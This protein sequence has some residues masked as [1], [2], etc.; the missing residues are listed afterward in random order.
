MD[1]FDELLESTCKTMIKTI[2]ACLSNAVKGTI[3]RI[4]LMPELTAVRITSGIRGHHSDVIEWGLPAKSDYN[5]PGKAWEEYRDQ[6][7]RVMEAMGWCVEKQ[8]SWTAD[9]PSEDLRSVR[10]QLAGEVEDHYHMEPVLVSKS[11]LYGSGAGRLRYPL[12]WRGNTI[13]RDSDYVVAAVIKIHFRPG[14]IRRDDGSTHIIR[15]LSQSLGTE[16]LSLYLRDTLFRARKDFARQRLQSCEILAHELRNTLAKL[17]FVFS[18]INAQIAILRESWEAHLREHVPGLE[19]K[20]TILERLSRELEQKCAGLKPDRDLLAAAEELLAAQNELARLSLSPYQE[21]EWVRNKIRPRW[22]RLLSRT[23]LWDRTEIIALLD[24]L[25]KSLRTGMERG[26]LGKINGI[27][28]EIVEKWSRLAYV[29]INSSNLFQI[30]EVIQ[31]V[32]YP[33]LPVAHKEQIIRVLKSLRALVVIIPEVEEKATRILQ[34][35]RYGAW[36]EDIV[37]FTP[38]PVVPESDG[39]FGVA[40]TD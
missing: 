33:L 37:R 9:N 35:L 15:D 34:S 4:G 22:E 25:L 16:L 3:Y 21:Q 11:S 17:G 20:S 29:S 19:W 8:Q 1:N 31:L 18:A 38:G 30:D 14:T 26:L 24:R 23:V 10:K 13:W 5:P 28:P 39:E 7:G 6:P 32:E 36:A 40:L 12:D 27:P 2:L